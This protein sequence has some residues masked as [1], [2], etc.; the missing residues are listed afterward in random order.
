[1]LVKF[2]VSSGAGLSVAL[3]KSES[4]EVRGSGFSFC[5]G[6]GLGVDSFPEAE[7]LKG[8]LLVVVVLVLGSG[9]LLS[10]RSTL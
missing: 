2:F 6:D 1:V 10:S 9:R 8:F 7:N 4:P 5:L 3:S